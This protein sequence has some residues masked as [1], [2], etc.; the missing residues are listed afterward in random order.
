[1]AVPWDADSAQAAYQRQGQ[2][3]AAMHGARA[4]EQAG[5]L[6]E[7]L[8][9][10]LLTKQGSLLGDSGSQPLLFSYACDATSLRVSAQ[11][12]T[13]L[14]EG[15]RVTRTGKTLIEFLL[16]RGLVYSIS[17]TGDIRCALVLPDPRPMNEGKSAWHDFAAACEAYPLLRKRRAQG[18]LVI[19][20]VAADRAVLSALAR[21]LQHR[22]QAYYTEG[23]G[24]A[25]SPEQLPLLEATDLMVATSCACHDAHNGLRWSLAE[26]QTEEVLKDLHLSLES[27]RNS[28]TSLVGTLP[29]FMRL[30]VTFSRDRADLGR[31]RCCSVG[32]SRAPQRP[33]C[34]SC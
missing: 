27:L 6:V 32:A 5:Q 1:M 12:S 11:A 3:C 7:A 24:P 21:A 10:L 20:H 13:R 8:K 22:R 9:E 26:Y 4:E 29:Q 33:R 14:Q 16:Q 23:L 34:T 18:G 17:A 25:H 15:V 2:A 30:H 19:T 31:R 28:F